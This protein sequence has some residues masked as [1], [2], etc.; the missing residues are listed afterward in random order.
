LCGGGGAGLFAWGVFVFFL[1]G[2]GV[3]GDPTQ[4]PRYEGS[5]PKSTPERGNPNQKRQPARRRAENGKV[6]TAAKEVQT[7]VKG[8]TKGG[9]GDW[10]YGGPNTKGEHN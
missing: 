5:F 7:T 9:S 6:V 2:C 1:G 8:R 4:G 3:S 10:Q